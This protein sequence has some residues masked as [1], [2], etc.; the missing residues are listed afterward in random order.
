MLKSTRHSVD[1]GCIPHRAGLAFAV[2][3]KQGPA[4]TRTNIS[5]VT[6]GGLLHVL[7]RRLQRGYRNAAASSASLSAV[8]PSPCVA[9]M[10]RTSSPLNSNGSV[11]NLSTTCTRASRF[12]S[13]SSKISCSPCTSQRRSWMGTCDELLYVLVHLSAKVAAHF[14]CMQCHFAVHPTRLALNTIPYDRYF[15]SSWAYLL[16]LGGDLVW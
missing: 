5:N 1:A 12:F 4:R 10:L 3:P 15:W 11:H 16:G 6:I 14:Q 8:T 9:M 7:P 2:R 13:R